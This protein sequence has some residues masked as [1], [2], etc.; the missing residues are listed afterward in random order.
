MTI[1]EIIGQ[2]SIDRID[3]E[4]ILT[5]V[6]KKSRS[7][8]LAHDE[9]ESS[10][11]QKNQC[12]RLFKRRQ[13]KEP[14]AYIIC[15]KEFY[16][17]EFYVTKDVLIPRPATEGLIDLT[18]GFLKKPERRIVKLDAGIIGIAKPFNPSTLQPCI[19]DI[20]T[21][22][23]CIA[24]TLALEGC[25]QKIIG[26]DISKKAR[27]VAEK[28]RKKFG[29][30]NV[31]FVVQDGIEFVG[32][33]KQPFLLVSNPPYVASGT[34]LEKTVVEFEPHGALFAGKDGMDIIRP[35]LKAAKGNKKCIGVI[36]EMTSDMLHS[37]RNC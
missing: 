18:L 25:T 15:S 6:L 5:H 16:G 9:E 1:R 11:Q 34:T 29:T 28:N 2:S 8:L 22:S 13:N 24:I 3:T 20:G 4:L 7:W 31:H 21:G 33:M 37:C 12:M 14:L 26:V 17:R 35:L 19:V 10:L 30:K 27:E 36:L 23:G 32:S